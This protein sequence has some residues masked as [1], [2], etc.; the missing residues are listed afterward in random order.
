VKPKRDG[1]D[2]SSVMNEKTPEGAAGKG[3]AQGAD[4]A[5][6]ARG[7]EGA[8]GAQSVIPPQKVSEIASKVRAGE[9]SRSEA[10]NLIVEQVVESQLGPTAGAEVKEKLA[11]RLRE[12]LE[13]D[14]FLS[15]KLQSLGAENGSA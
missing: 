8:K 11:E 3:P 14:P 15:R 2:F 9:V 12:V 13:N 4:K 1:P 5:Q 7:A 10:M 6:A